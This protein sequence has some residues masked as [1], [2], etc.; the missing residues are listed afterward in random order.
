MTKDFLYLIFLH[1][2]SRLSVSLSTEQ[3]CN[4][5]VYITNHRESL[6]QSLFNYTHNIFLIQMILLSKRKERNLIL[7]YVKEQTLHLNSK[8]SKYN[9]YDDIMLHVLSTR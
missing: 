9:I 7:Y 6:K 8:S 4:V 1:A 3:Y 5:Y 2:V